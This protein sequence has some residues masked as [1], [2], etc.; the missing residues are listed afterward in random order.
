MEGEYAPREAVEGR[1]TLCRLF[2][3]ASLYL[4]STSASGFKD[5]SSVKKGN[6][7]S[8][9]V[10]TAQLGG[11]VSP[12]SADSFTNQHKQRDTDGRGLRGRTA[13]SLCTIRMQIWLIWGRI[14]FARAAGTPSSSP[15]PKLRVPAV[16]TTPLPYHCYGPSQP[17]SF[18]CT[19]H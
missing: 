17:P 8:A 15:A 6:R 4:F 10:R 11:N 2:L 16:L 5:G 1:K 7:T 14:S 19:Y 3:E 13:C 9:H 12:A 18:R